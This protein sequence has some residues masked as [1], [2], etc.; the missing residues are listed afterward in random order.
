M[1]TYGGKS[2]PAWVRATVRGPLALA[3]AMT[4]L[5]VVLPAV[6][7][8]FAWLA[9]REDVLPTGPR[10]ISI[11]GALTAAATALGGVFTA[12]SDRSKK[13]MPSGEGAAPF[14]GSATSIV[15]RIGG[16]PLTAIVV[17]LVL[18]L[19]AFFGL[20][21]LSWSAV[22]AHGWP[23]GWKLGL[24][25]AL[26]V[27][28]ILIDQTTFSLHP[29]YRQRLAGAFAVRRA[30]LRDGSVGAV[31]YDYNAESTRLS[32]HGRRAE[33]FPQVIFAASAALSLRNRTAP[34]RPRC[35]SPSPTT[36]WA[37]RT[38]DGCA[39]PRWRRPRTR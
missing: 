18:L 19:L 21:L 31:P 4:V 2:R 7:W 26:L 6:F 34:G 37:D 11:L 29:F 39:R 22:S 36:G 30:V 24:P 35:P 23:L 33:G 8:F 3:A 32:T 15:T 25:I 16:G 12:V 17:W 9:H 5:V 20:S 27:S 14:R 1:F 13:L 28:A 38:P 10:G